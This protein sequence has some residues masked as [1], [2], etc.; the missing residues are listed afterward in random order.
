[1]PSLPHTQIESEVDHFSRTYEA[2]LFILD[3]LSSPPYRVL[4]PAPFLPIN[5]TT[6]A[7]SAMPVAVTQPKTLYDK[8]WDDHVMYA[9][10]AHLLL[11][12]ASC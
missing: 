10:S 11:R 7:R 9:R 3:R 12:L 4:S 1:M 6:R 5:D 8:I 2:Y